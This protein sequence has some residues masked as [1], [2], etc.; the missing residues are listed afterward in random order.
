MAENPNKLIKF[1]QELK[2]RKVFKVVAMYAATAYIIIEVINNLVGPLHLPE[3]IA[4][5]L[6]LL[7][8]LGLPIV[9]ILSWIFDFTPEGIKKTESIE[10]I[11]SKETEAITHP[12]KKRLR[13]SDFTIAALIIIVVILAYPKI[14]NRNRLENLRSSDGK[15]SVAVMPFDNLTGDTTLNYFEKGISSLITALAIHRNCL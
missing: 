8:L 7:L 9:V 3:W 12:A 5:L 4:T 6:V 11:E 2:R 13:V 10:E 1:W 14:F 15:I